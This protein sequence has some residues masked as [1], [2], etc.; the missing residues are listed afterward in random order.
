MEMPAGQSDC[1]MLSF[2]NR[3]EWKLT[4]LTAGVG[5]RMEKAALQRVSGRKWRDKAES[6]GRRDAKSLNVFPP[7]IGG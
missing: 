5:G 7:P 4:R 1:E 3:E 6:K 2:K